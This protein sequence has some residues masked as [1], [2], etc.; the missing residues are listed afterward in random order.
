MRLTPSPATES[1]APAARPAGCVVFV[2]AGPG[3]PD[4]LTV[5]AAE[6]I[7]HADV[8][9]HDQLVPRQLLDSLG[10]R[11]DCI[12][13]PR[14]NAA[15]DPGEATGRLLAGLATEGKFVVRLKG[16]DPTVF[17]RL[18]EELEPLRRQGVAVEF[19]P[20]ITAALAAAAAA[21]VPLT[22]RAAASSLTIVTGHEAGDKP[23]AVDLGR[24]A[25]APGTLVV[26]MGVDQVGRWSSDLVAAGRPPTTPVTI[27]SR[28]SWLDER[29][30]VTTLGGCAA[31]VERQRLQSP[32]V[33]IVGAAARP[34]A[35]GGPLQGRHVL[36]TRPAGQADELAT[37]VRGAGGTCGHVPLVRIE[38]P[39]SWEPLD[40]AIRRADRYDWIV[41]ASTN[42]V[43]NFTARMRAAGRDG[44]SLGTARI[45]A[46]G[47]ATRR[48]LLAA[49]LVADLAPRVF[50]SEGLAEA[51]ADAPRGS[52]FLLVRA[53][54]GRES[55]R[56]SLEPA[57]HA[58]DEVT[59]YR[60]V[61]VEALEAD[62]LAAIDRAGID[63]ITVTSP[64]IAGAAVRC[65]GER[66]DRWKIASISP[67]TS[68][69]LHRAGVRETVEAARATMVDLVAAIVQFEAAGA[70][71]DALPS[72]SPQP[73]GPRG[74][75]DPAGGARSR[76]RA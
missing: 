40:E 75:T 22:S 12:A 50:S 57:G 5:R 68:A 46:V 34:S 58:V 24:L 56:Q 65:F 20:G 31:E 30:I 42:G 4:L 69:A 39:A 36:L 72:G 7:R 10:A 67:L 25:A 61:P 15:G 43:R 51:F 9:V 17:A 8:V 23:A 33:I 16:G 49:G 71:A 60:S 52:R 1:S 35:G 18:A 66:L 62:T 6:A 11:A 55:L 53:D 41:F 44:R 26:Y 2:G 19:V 54:L 28:C 70:A 47:P 74:R 14:G 48:E 3:A 64:A 38:P 73:A 32:A 45:A 59:A 13:A 37:L 76:H 63:W 29:I 27:V 21:G